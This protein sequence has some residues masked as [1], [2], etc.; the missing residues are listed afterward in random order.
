MKNSSWVLLVAAGGSLLLGGQAIA[1]KSSV[2]IGEKLFGD[3][4]LGGSSNT[5]NCNSC[6][7]NGEG[8]TKSADSKKLVKLMNKCITDKLEGE[9]IDGRS[10]KMRSLKMYIKSLAR[11]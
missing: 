2:E 10:A 6:H 8:L 5:K 11:N 9:K 7:A 1:A 3:P 4:T